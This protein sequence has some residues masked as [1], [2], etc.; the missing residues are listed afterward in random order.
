MQTNPTWNDMDNTEDK[1]I[2]TGR[3]LSVENQFVDDIVPLLGIDVIMNPDKVRNS[4][5]PDL[6]RNGEQLADLKKQTT[7]FF[8][9]GRYDLD[10]QYTVTFNRKDYLRYKHHYPNIHI[11]FWV[12]W[13]RLVYTSNNQKWRTIS[14]Q[15]LK[16]VW[17]VPFSELALQIETGN[18]PLHIY[19]RRVNDTVGNAKDSYVFDVRTF[20]HVRTL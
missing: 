3:A 16:S 6:L 17:E 18:I 14:L 5:A 12:D 11:Y 19:V 20:T 8:T 1:R 7:P 2:W 9:S 15:P 10:P 13:E 4:Y